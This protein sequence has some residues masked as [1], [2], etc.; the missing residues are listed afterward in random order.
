MSVIDPNLPSSEI[1]P[2]PSEPDPEPSPEQPKDK[3]THASTI[4]PDDMSTLVHH[5]DDIHTIAYNTYYMGA[6][7]LSFIMVCMLSCV[8]LIA[9]R[10]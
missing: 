1:E 3:N 2:P 9:L 10:R 8:L 5:V 6:F 4:N 7:A